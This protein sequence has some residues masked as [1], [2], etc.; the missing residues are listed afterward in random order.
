[1]VPLFQ[2]P[3]HLVSSTSFF[4][5]ELSN[6][7][8]IEEKQEYTRYKMLETLHDHELDFGPY[9]ESIISYQF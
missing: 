8:N 7:L 9:L 4:S 6:L 1:M 2:I 5:L 3:C